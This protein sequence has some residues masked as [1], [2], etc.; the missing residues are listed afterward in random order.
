[1]PQR[2]LEGVVEQS[3]ADMNAQDQHEG[4]IRAL[5][6]ENADLRTELAAARL[7]TQRAR[8]ATDRALQALRRQL[9][10]LYKALQQVF[11]E[12][13]AAG[14]AEEEPSAAATGVAHGDYGGQTINPRHAAVWASWKTKLGPV[15][16]RFIDALLIHGE[17]NVAQLK[18]T[19]QCG[20]QT[21]Y[22][23]MK[24]LSD[25]GLINKAN[26]GKYSLKALP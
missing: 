1:M 18:V 13:A 11:G 14:V 21:V 16:A 7:E 4:E 17:M 10:P 23:H 2:V 15:T 24:K 9:A 6:E 20:T 26:R 3:V 8:Q 19:C 5:E 22:D 25:V 12:L